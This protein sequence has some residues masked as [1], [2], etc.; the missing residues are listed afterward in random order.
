MEAT[1]AQL[2]EA[3]ARNEA[4][5]REVSELTIQLNRANLRVKEL[6]GQQCVLLEQSDRQLAEA[7]T[8]LERLRGELAGTSTRRGVRSTI[9][10][11]VPVSTTSTVP[12]TG[13]HSRGGAQRRGKAP[14]VESFSGE[15]EAVRIDDWLPALERAATWNDWS[16]EDR[17]LQ[18]AG[19]LRGRA[20][21]EWELISEDDKSSYPQAR[22]DPGSR[23]L[24]AQDFRHTIQSD[25]ESVADL[26]RRLER[27]FRVAYGIASEARD[28]LLYGQ[29]HEGLRFEII[30]APGVSGVDSYSS[31]CIAAKSEERRL[32]ELRKRQQYGKPS[33]S[34]QPPR[35]LPPSNTT[36]N[37][38]PIHRGKEFK[39]G[40]NFI[41]RTGNCF[42]CDQA[43]P[44]K[45]TESNGSRPSG[46]VK[47]LTAEGSESGDIPDVGDLLDLLLSDSEDE[48]VNLVQVPDQGSRSRGFQL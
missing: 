11:S 13:H 18:L 44:S 5:T 40:S 30:K 43:S 37:T 23:A 28:A 31:L 17:L 8:E 21:Q 10:A 2:T 42:V 4:L 19:H 20:L 7:E 27:N 41:K 6:W 32:Q 12:R 33:G 45:R 34:K 22:L 35:G 9:P 47:L 1:L 3:E 36:P 26:I 16:E 38:T 15:N 14:P 39:G 29:L 48:Q 46:S 24:A 25:T